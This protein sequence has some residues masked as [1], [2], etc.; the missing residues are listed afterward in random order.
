MIV[1]RFVTT[2]N[3]ITYLLINENDYDIFNSFIN[4]EN[5]SLGSMNISDTIICTLIV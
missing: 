1:Q 4:S 3:G 2:I 5:K